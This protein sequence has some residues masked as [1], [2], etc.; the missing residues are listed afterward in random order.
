MEFNGNNNSKALD[1]IFDSVQK[2]I[3]DE[4][5][6]P[7]ENLSTPIL[8]GIS[9]NPKTWRRPSIEFYVRYEILHLTLHC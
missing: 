6:I 2:E 3:R 8:L 7:I 5:N 9:Y 4:I 1:E